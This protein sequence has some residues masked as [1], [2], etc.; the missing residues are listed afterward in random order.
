MGSSKRRNDINL[1][2]SI[3]ELDR[4]LGK[5]SQIMEGVVDDQHTLKD[6]ADELT[7]IRLELKSLDAQNKVLFKLF[8]VIYKM[9]DEPE[10]PHDKFELFDVDKVQQGS[11]HDHPA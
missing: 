8:G 6:I 2:V 5:F 1:P 3:R 4:L 9:L 11:I 7:K 10:K